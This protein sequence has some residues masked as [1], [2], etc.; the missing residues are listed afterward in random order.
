MLATTG[1]ITA[2][3]AR[4]ATPSNHLLARDNGNKKKKNVF[5]TKFLTSLTSLPPHAL[6]HSTTG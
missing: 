5:G 3:F 6:N 2:D 1:T 4:S